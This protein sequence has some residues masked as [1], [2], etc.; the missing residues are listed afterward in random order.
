MGRLLLR[1][2]VARYRLAVAVTAQPLGASVSVKSAFTKC[3]RPKRVDSN[4]EWAAD[5]AFVVRRLLA[6]RFSLSPK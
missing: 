2:V 5:G 4:I 3:E 1:L 6:G